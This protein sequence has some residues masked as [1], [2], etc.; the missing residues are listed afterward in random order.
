MDGFDRHTS[1][2]S[3][4]DGFDRPVLMELKLGSATSKGEDDLKRVLLGFKGSCRREGGRHESYSVECRSDDLGRRRKIL[5]GLAWLVESE[6]CGSYREGKIVGA[7]F[8]FATDDPISPGSLLYRFVNGDDAFRNQL[9]KIVN[10]IVKGL[11]IM[12]K[13]VGEL[14]RLF[15]RGT[16]YLEIDVDIGS[17]AIASAILHLVLGGSC[18]SDGGR[19]G[20]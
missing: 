14:Q 4:M 1:I 3:S 9:F 20:S 8:Y 11:W 19:K 17:S 6:S 7:V 13:M 2:L 12:K 5:T 15:I 18:G 16:N 10:R